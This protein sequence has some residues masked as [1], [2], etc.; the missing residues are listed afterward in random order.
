MLNRAAAALMLWALAGAAAHSQTAD[1]ATAWREDLQAARSQFLE[2]DRSYAPA[3]RRAAEAELGRL[4]ASVDRLS[5]VQIVAG[6]ARVAAVSENA[7]TRAYL[8]RNRG[9]WRRYPVRI[10][11]FEEGWYVIAA[12]PGHEH[13]LGRRIVSVAGRPVQDA[14][15]ALRPL[16]AGNDGW[17]DYMATYTLTSPDALIGQGLLS[18]DGEA[19]WEVRDP[20]GRVRRVRLSPEPFEPR[21]GAEESWWFLSP[22]HAAVKGWRQVLA[23]RALPPALRA[24]NR[25]YDL[26]RCADG[27]AYVPFTRAQR[28]SQTDTLDTFAKRL[29]GE[30]E[31]DPP[32][33]LI[34]DLRFNTGGD[35]SQGFPL[36]KALAASRLGQEHGRTFVVMGPSTFS[37]GISHA[38]QM[39]Q[40]SRAVFV[41]TEPGDDLETWSE[42][43]NIVLPHS[44]LTLRPTDKAHTYSKAAHG[45]AKADVYLDLD[46]DHLRPDLPARWSWAAYRTGR[47]PFTEAV[48]DRP[49]RCPTEP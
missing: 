7:H 9:Y 32:R 44:K 33:K 18:G 31:A 4:E 5:D 20:G 24:V 17:A 19:A 27:V 39:R 6:L 42:G 1:R 34:L 23:G 22:E 48:L 45:L 2:K 30:V 8:L 14:A 29:L 46:I 28:Q 16:Y 35:L 25:N 40:F 26:L 21:D 15:R 36:F 13:L 37:A 12:R 43:A 47:D 11:R 41:G 49:L 3:A 10:W 38:A